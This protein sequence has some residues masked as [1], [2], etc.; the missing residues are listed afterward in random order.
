MNKKLHNHDERLRSIGNKH[1]HTRTYI[2][3][4]IFNHTHFKEIHNSEETTSMSNKTTPSLRTLP[5]EIV[6]R[7]LDN[8]SPLTIILS[9]RDVCARL[10]L[11]I[12]KYYRYQVNF[13][14]Y[15]QVRFL[16]ASTHRSFQL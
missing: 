8:L 4:N 2:K 10:N 9:L 5:V 3:K 12:D 13:T 7:I 6:Y 14:F 1:T 11:I 16:A 15:L